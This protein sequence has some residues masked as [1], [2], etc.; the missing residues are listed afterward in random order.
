ME[1]M[2]GK[3]LDEIWSDRLSEARA[4]RRPGSAGGRG[5]AGK[6]GRPKGRGRGRGMAARQDG[7]RGSRKGIGRGVTGVRRSISG[8]AGVRRSINAKAWKKGAGATVWGR[9]SKGK[10]KSR[11]KGRGRGGPV[12]ALTWDDDREEPRRAKGKGNSRGKGVG[13][14]RRMAAL[15]WDGGWEGESR[16][17][18]SA[19]KSRGKGKGK[20]KTAGA[21]L[22]L[23]ARN[24]LGI[25]RTI[26]KTLRGGRAKGDGAKGRGKGK[27]G[28]SGM[29]ALTNGSASYE[30]G[31]GKR[32]GG[33]KSRGKGKGERRAS[34]AEAYELEN[35]ERRGSKGSSKGGSKSGSKGDVINE[36]RAVYFANADF[37]SHTSDL[38]DHF[39][40]VGPIAK[41]TLFTLADG[42]SRGMGVV[43]YKSVANAERAVWRL[44]DAAVDG[45][46][47]LVKPYEA[48]SEW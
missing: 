13:R 7:G 11:S 29:L 40:Q 46:Q 35:F 47:L 42:R 14:G 23:A 45:R 21:S 41:F 20:R 12:A 43:E 10:G 28:G 2:V 8:V 4:S 48:G 31:K 16:S 26:G 30:K 44:S 1:R 17:G 3:T 5:G 22:G 36:R 9:A 6:G 19:G 15:T 18:K 27:G 33:A 24:F 32:T 37:N 39:E 38:V 34:Q 25:K